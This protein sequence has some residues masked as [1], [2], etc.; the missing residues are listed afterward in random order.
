MKKNGDK[1]A[2]ALRI[3]TI[4][5]LPEN[6]NCSDCN[7][8]NPAWADLLLGVL[9]CTE[10]SGI[11]RKMGGNISYVKSLSFGS[12]T[13]VHLSKLETINNEKANLEY[14]QSPVLKY[15]QKPK[16]QDSYNVK[17]IW[18]YSKYNTR[19]WR[20]SLVRAEM[21]ELKKVIDGLD[22]PD[23]EPLQ[24][25]FLL[26]KRSSDEWEKIFVQIQGNVL[27]YST[28]SKKQIT[29]PLLLI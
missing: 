29:F 14:E 8:L 22:N 26:R 17:H 6:K 25:G 5:N 18:I 10:C 9:I 13:N 27:L 12:W 3:Q 16:E 4:K 7:K 15:L 23:L 28:E 11:H 2:S 20:L 1:S 19:K 21:S 24:K